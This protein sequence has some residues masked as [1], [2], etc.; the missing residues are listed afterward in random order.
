LKPVIGIS[1]NISPPDDDK[2]NF[3]KGVALNYLQDYYSRWVEAGGGAAVL[4]APT[5]P[6]ESAGIIIE[7]LDGIIISGGVDVDPQLYGEANTHSKGCDPD[8]D[9]FEIELVLEARRLGKA[10]LGI[11]RGIQIVNVAFGGTLVQD[12][13]S[14]IP[15]PL[16]HHRI[17]EGEE[18][19]HEME[20][21]GD[22][23]FTKVFGVTHNRV[24]SSHHQ[25][26]K[27]PGEGLRIVAKA[28]DG[29]VEAVVSTQDQCIGGIQWHPERMLDDIKQVELARWF[30]ASCK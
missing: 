28:G 11:C 16:H 23:F 6:V 1:V 3:S 22:S 24:N 2:R 5:K 4:L 13:P 17:V 18:M 7:H 26:V 20:L 10:A 15:N 8:R 14:Q 29:V 30:V 12:I 21:V 25:S 19:F 9:R 27:E